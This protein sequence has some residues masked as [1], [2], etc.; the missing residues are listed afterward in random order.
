MST[1]FNWNHIPGIQHDGEVTAKTTSTT[2]DHFDD[3]FNHQ[4]NQQ[5]QQQHPAQPQNTQY[6]SSSLSVPETAP[7]SLSLLN[8]TAQSENSLANVFNNLNINNTKSHSDD[9]INTI[10]AGLNSPLSV[11]SSP[12]KPISSLHNIMENPTHS[13]STDTI[14]ADNDSS[15]PLSLALN[16][17]SQP[18][19]KTYLRWYENIQ[20][21]KITNKTV[22]IDDVFLFMHNFKI[23]QQIKD[24]MKLVFTKWSNSLNIGQFFALMRLL[25]HA[26]LGKPLARSLIKLPAPVPRPISILS[27]KRKAN[28][29]DST[30]KAVTLNPNEP[31]KKLDIDSFTEFILTGERPVSSPP[32][33]PLSNKKVKFSE[34]LSYSSSPP[35]VANGVLV[36]PSN[37]AVQSPHQILDFSLPMDQLLDKLKADATGNIPVIEQPQFQLPP[38]PHIPQLTET[39]KE[40]LKDVQMDTFK[41]ITDKVAQENSGDQPLKPDLTGSASKS[42]K[43]HF[44][45]QFDQTFNFSP[46]TGL[47][48]NNNN[49]NNN[50]YQNISSLSAVPSLSQPI[51]GQIPLLSPNTEFPA[52]SSTQYSPIQETPNINQLSA[53][54]QPTDYFG[55]TQTNNTA[56]TTPLISNLVNGISS[57]TNLQALQALQAPQ[58][59]VSRSRSSS[60]VSPP[61]VPP[62]PPPPRSRKSSRVIANSTNIQQSSHPVLPPKP[63][64]NEQQK[65]QYLSA[66][67]GVQLKNANSMTNIARENS[68]QYLNSYNVNVN[69]M[70]NG[71]NNDQIQQL[72]QMNQLSQLHQMGSM[73][74]I[75]NRN[76]GNNV[77]PSGN[78]MAYGQQ[79]NMNQTPQF[80]NQFITQQTGGGWPSLQNPNQQQPIQSQAQSQQQQ[81]QQLNQP[82]NQQ[83][84]NA[85]AGWSY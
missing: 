6:R 51:G 20:E 64:L 46:T 37:A 30:T 81:P 45:Q 72:N 24:R 58:P 25:A 22:T 34:V 60:S 2:T 4:L 50:T 52:V 54:N 29:S 71:I 78:S 83:Q 1:N 38:Q 17:M 73:N 33:N 18:E 27:R 49:N 62:P 70:N 26:L 55:M 79:N 13:S 85:W 57:N 63:V 23:P 36:Q 35:I 10:K 67:E 41:T 82:L 40:E 43:E 31:K 11:N 19:L 80:P 77:Y 32:K 61:P 42:M 12:K 39:E 28:P 66:S 56:L 5:Q 53:A 84:T 21:R 48:N 8:K 15:I 65:Q 47:F 76:T 69:V 44:L 16:D 7:D 9:T 3:F 59:P 68:M 14:I 74:N 75:N